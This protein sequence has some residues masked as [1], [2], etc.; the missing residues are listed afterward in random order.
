MKVIPEKHRWVNIHAV[1]LLQA[2]LLGLRLSVS[3]AEPSLAAA[4]L[5]F[6]MASVETDSVQCAVRLRAA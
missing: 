1:Q 6:H 4:L 2:F 5:S 3:V